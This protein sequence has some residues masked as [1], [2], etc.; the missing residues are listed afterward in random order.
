MP[1]LSK[2]ARND[3]S[4][5]RELLVACSNLRQPFLY[6]PIDENSSENCQGF[7]RSE[8]QQQGRAEL[9]AAKRVGDKDEWKPEK[10]GKP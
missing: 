3:A 4:S 9:L 1:G 6:L 2:P 5:V 8:D 10:R 7:C